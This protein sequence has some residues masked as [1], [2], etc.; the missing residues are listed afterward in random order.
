MNQQEAITYDKAELR[1]ILRALRNM[2]EEATTQARKVSGEL[3]GMAL[4]Q[5]QRAASGPAQSKI[6]QGGRVSRSSKIGEFSFGYVAQKYSGGGTT[7]QLWP[8]YEFGSGRITQFRPWSGQ[9]GRGSKGKFIYPTLRRIQPD[10]VRRWEEALAVIMRK[11][12]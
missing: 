2:D 7:Q 6:A 10:I 12:S 11:W 3:A 8:G 9:Q 1:S 4:E 5:I